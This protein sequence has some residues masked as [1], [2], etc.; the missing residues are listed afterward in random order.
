MLHR[1]A[2][3]LM[4]LAACTFTSVAASAEEG[5]GDDGKE[6]HMGGLGKAYAGGFIS[7][8][9][10]LEKSLKPLFGESLHISEASLMVGG[11]G[12]GMI[13]G[14]VIAGGGHAILTPTV[15]GAGGEVDVIG[16]GGGLAIGYAFYRSRDWIVY[17]YVG[18][19]GYGLTLGL[20]NDSEENVDLGGEVL[21]PG[22]SIDLITGFA[23]VDL[24]VSAQQ[25]LFFGD[26]G[27]A[28]GMDLGVLLSVAG[29]GFSTVDAD[30][31]T[32]VSDT[33]LRGFYMRMTIGGGGFTFTR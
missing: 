23:A 32:A 8:W 12:F 31:I 19:A 4:I 16:G 13:G 33:K 2:T 1:V 24:G 10:G 18:G 27:F 3:T 7:G 17:P 15:D 25:L 29:G 20:T 5:A 11:G 22:E 28:L 14:F 30:E 26:G 6:P 9:G 21:E